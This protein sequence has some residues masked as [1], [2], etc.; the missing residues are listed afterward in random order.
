MLTLTIP[1]QP[2]QYKMIKT[3]IKSFR[4]LRQRQ[5]WK[6]HVDGGAYVIEMTGRP[7][8]W[9]AHIHMIIMSRWMKWEKLLRIWQTVSPGRGVWIDDIPQSEAVGYVT[10]YISK[11]SVPDHLNLEVN[12]A[13]KGVRL[14]S[15]FGSW[16]STNLKYVKPSLVCGE[17]GIGTFVAM[18]MA[19][20]GHFN[21]FEIEFERPPPEEAAS[22]QMFPT[23]TK[24]NSAA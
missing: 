15:P 1:N 12:L 8:N 3:I 13:L 16:H 22:L 21:T 7:A 14:F 10:K 4:K 6:N 19:I 11:L 2:D 17:C 5:Y 9:H 18:S 23:V 20:D 24:S